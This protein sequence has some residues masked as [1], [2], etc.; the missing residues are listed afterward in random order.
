MLVEKSDYFVTVG[1][2]FEE[3]MYGIY[4]TVNPDGILRKIDFDKLVEQW[5]ELKSQCKKMEME[6]TVDSTTQAISHFQ[7]FEG[8]ITYGMVK[9]RSGELYRI[10]IAELSKQKMLILLPERSPYFTLADSSSNVVVPF[11]QNVADIFIDASYDICE[12]GRCLATE[13]DTACVLHLMRVLEIGLQRLADRFNIPFERANWNTIIDQIESAIRRISTDSPRP[14]NWKHEEE[15]Y[16]RVAKEFRYIKDSWRNHAMHSRSRYD[17]D[18]AKTIYS[19][20]REFMNELAS[21]LKAGG[22]VA[23]S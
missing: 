9:T 7:R 20:T 6:M 12:A 4:G 16:A 22:Q 1:R 5:G 15:R 19:H 8:Q 3:L 13:L 11:G 2:M 18:E 14:A 21:L 23:R 10:F 17:F